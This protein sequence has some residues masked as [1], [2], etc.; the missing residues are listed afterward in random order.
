VQVSKAILQAG[1]Q[2]KI[3]SAS[4]LPGTPNLL[5]SS[6][7]YGIYQPMTVSASSGP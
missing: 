3:Q 6:D 7:L 4:M 5:L 2:G 1:T